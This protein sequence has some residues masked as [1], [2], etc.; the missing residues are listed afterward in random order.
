MTAKEC[1][2]SHAVLL[3]CISRCRSATK[4]DRPHAKKY[5]G[6]ED[7]EQTHESVG[8]LGD[9]ASNAEGNDKGEDALVSGCA[10]REC[11]REMARHETDGA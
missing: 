8:D 5:G 10:K 9:H 1:D 4:G 2:S 7:D 11:A 3:L 6:D